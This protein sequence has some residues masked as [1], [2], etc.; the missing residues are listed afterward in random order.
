MAY[1]FVTAE[2]RDEK[3]KSVPGKELCSTRPRM[4]ITFESCVSMSKHD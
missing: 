2:N 4:Q 3:R 1:G